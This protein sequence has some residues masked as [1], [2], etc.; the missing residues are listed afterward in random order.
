MKSSGPALS[1]TGFIVGVATFWAWFGWTC[2]AEWARDPD[3]A[4]GWVVMPLAVYFL[5]KRLSAA[6]SEPR[7]HAVF[8]WAV[9]AVCAL[10][11][12]P[13][14][15]GRQA[16]LYWRVFAWAVYVTTAAATLGLA[17]LRG[18]T[19]YL[20]ASIF[21]VAFVGT[22]VPWPT[23]IEQPVTIALAQAVAALVGEVLPVLGIPA[24]IEGTVIALPAC[25]VGIAE[26]CSGVRS[27]QSALMIA[28]AV[29]EW[30]ML[31][32]WRRL[33]LIPVG[34]AIA[35]VTNFARTLALS[36][37][38]AR[39]GNEALNAMHDPAGWMAWV[40]LVCGIV[41]AGR[42]L[43]GPW[44]REL[45]IPESCERPTSQR[46]AGVAWIWMVALVGLGVAGGQGWYLMN[47]MS[48]RGGGH[49]SPRLSVSDTADTVPLPEQM[50]KVLRPTSG[51]YLRMRRDGLVPV[52]GY[53]LI[54]DDSKNNSEAL[55][56]RPDACM[57]GVGWRL[58]G[59]AEVASSRIDGS[60]VEWTALH[61]EK[62]GVRVLLLWT[63]WLDGEPMRFSLHSGASVQQNVLMRLIAN[64]RR[65][66]SYE[67]AAVMLPYEGSVPPM[68]EAVRAAEQIFRY[69]EPH[70][71]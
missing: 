14:E 26:A 19:G 64:G 45:V 37:A 58:V 61:Y 23:A 29:G 20:R 62:D 1:R 70:E 38:G 41:V 40:L 71:E 68:S 13:I 42:L 67:V 33:F 30:M 6:T 24:R 65:N 46:S 59:P 28:F 36:L 3:Y 21:P 50:E 31:G 22:A 66:F 53:H 49:R 43:K 17:F 69:S 48:A 9:V 8:A 32:W 63:A 52:T 27:L 44:E 60:P 56:H 55:Y 35:L 11:V 54:W 34:F 57:P 5:W 10:A 25:T 12:L 51:G 2:A 18:G 39:G 7:G 15:L 16:P 47:E 4:H